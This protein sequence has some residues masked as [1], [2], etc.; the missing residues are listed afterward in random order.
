M[1]QKNNKSSDIGLS[2][3]T[4]VDTH[5]YRLQQSSFVVYEEGPGKKGLAIFFLMIRHFFSEYIGMSY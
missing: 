3:L 5:N 1:Y 4:G 2:Y